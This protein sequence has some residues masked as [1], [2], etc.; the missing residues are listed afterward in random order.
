MDISTIVGLIIAFGGLLGG[1]AVEKGNVAS[2]VSLSPFLIVFGGTL[3]A[4]ILSCGFHDLFAAMKSF[5]DSLF[6][7]NLPNPE[8]LI[9]KLCDI[10]EISRREG[11][12]KLQTVLNDPDLSSDNYLP[13]KEG[14]VLA[15]E[16]KSMDEIR[17]AMESDIA[18][19]SLQKQLQIEAFQSAGGYSPTMGVIGTVM[20]LVQVL[21][22]MESA[23]ELTAAIG[24]AFIAT[25]YGVVFANLIYLPIANRLKAVLKRERVYREMMIEGVCLIVSGKSPRDVENQLSLYYHAF[26]GKEKL[27]KQ[28]I[29]N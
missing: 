15:L 26:P 25:L 14:I 17:D 16:M 7:K 22:N 3:G 13:L 9:K 2:L 12:V 28:G 27:Y 10:A 29:N 23:E 20:G 8:K 24:V 1:Y 11:L 6:T 21:G 18:S 4:T 19:F 5:V